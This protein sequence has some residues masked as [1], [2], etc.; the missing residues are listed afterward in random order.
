MELVQAEDEL[1][2]KVIEKITIEVEISVG[3]A[4]LILPKNEGKEGKS[5]IET[6]MSSGSHFSIGDGTLE[7]SMMKI[8]DNTGTSWGASLF[9]VS[10]SGSLEMESCDVRREEG[11]QS[12]EITVS[13]FVASGGSVK[14]KKTTFM[15]LVF[16]NT[17]IMNGM[18]GCNVILETCTFSGINRKE[19]NGSVIRVEV[20][21]EKSVTIKNSSFDKC[22]GLKGNGG[23][24]YVVLKSGGSLIV[25]ES[26]SNTKIDSCEATE[27]DGAKGFGGGI[28]L[29]CEDGGETFVLENIIFSQNEAE[30]G[31]NLFIDGEDLGRIIT[32]DSIVYDYDDNKLDEIVGFES[33][34]ESF[35][36]PLNL[37]LRT[38]IEKEFYVKNDGVNY[39]KCGY[40]DYPCETIDFCLS[41]LANEEE[42]LIII[43]I[44]RAHV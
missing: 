8:I 32:S 31:K 16:D 39:K 38:P 21:N 33:R 44:G 36:I 24:I 37:F 15:N 2:I 3:V 5:T 27:L 7:I 41:L 11:S 40:E 14:I 20:S 25:G 29:Y 43:E 1:T 9:S 35:F 19:G 13:L 28:F 26:G 12:K 10:S 22:V 30:K 34:I 23:G 6:K 4:K 17:G 42:V 18:S